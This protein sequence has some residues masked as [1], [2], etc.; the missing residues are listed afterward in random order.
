MKYGTE[1]VKYTA[2]KAKCA[3]KCKMHLQKL[4]NEK[5]TSEGAF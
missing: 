5:L 2:K 1:N 3:I 4:E